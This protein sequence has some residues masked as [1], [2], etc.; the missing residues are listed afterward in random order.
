MKRSST[1]PEGYRVIGIRY[2]LKKLKNR[3]HVEQDTL[4]PDDAADDIDHRITKAA[5]R[6]YKI[7]VVRGAMVALEEVRKGTIQANANQLRTQL[8]TMRWPKKRLNVRIGKRKVAVNLKGFK[9]RVIDDLG[10]ER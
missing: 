4:Y 8:S 10:F 6:W 1:S 5:M 3:G 7:G 9:L 2:A